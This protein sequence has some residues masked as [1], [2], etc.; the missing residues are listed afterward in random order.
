MKLILIVRTLFSYL[1]CGIGIILFIP[2]L[3]LLACLPARVRYNN[4]IFFILLSWFYRWVCFASLNRLQIHGLQNLPNTPALFVANH[5]SAFDI[6]VVGSLCYGAPHIW[7]VLA[8]Y[9]Q[10]PVLGFFIR[11]MFVPVER[12]Q[13]VK[14]AESL[15]KIIRFLQDRPRHLIIFPEGMRHADGAIHEFYEGFA[16]I[17]KRTGR[18]VIPVYMPNNIRIYPVSSFYIYSAPLDVIIGEPMYKEADETDTAFVNRVRQWFIN[19]YN[20]YHSSL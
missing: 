17:A 9:L 20:K 19:Q 6:P 14:A 4:L 2:P 8:Y 18:P 15:R 5:Q 7:L 12:D 13:P 16:L 10:T 11:R 3:F 1:L